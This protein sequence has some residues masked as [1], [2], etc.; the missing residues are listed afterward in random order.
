MHTTFLVFFVLFD[1]MQ[2]MI[3]NCEE[4]L[5][6]VACRL[7]VA[8]ALVTCR[9][10]VHQRIFG[11]LFFTNTGWSD[12]HNI[13]SPWYALLLSRFYVVHGHHS[14]FSI[15]ITHPACRWSSLFTNHFLYAIRIINNWYH[16]YCCFQMKNPPVW[17]QRRCR[18]RDNLASYFGIFWAV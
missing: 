4:E 18:R 1:K 17:T 2:W 3:S 8:V 12:N 9:P 15:F 5:V 11:E 7:A 13:M 6:L 14:I 10:T 16:C